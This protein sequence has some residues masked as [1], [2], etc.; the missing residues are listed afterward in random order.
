M[1]SSAYAVGLKGAFTWIMYGCERD[2][3]KQEMTKLGHPR[4]K[5]WHVAPQKL[6]H[7]DT[8]EPY[9]DFQASNRPVSIYDWWS[10]AKPQEEAIVLIGVDFYPRIR[11]AGGG[12]K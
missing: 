9:Q 4:A 8:G 7:P 5:V 1:L 3:Q 6:I 11:E 12:G 10:K 2:E